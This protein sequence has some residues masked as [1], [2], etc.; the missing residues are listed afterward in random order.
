MGVGIEVS[1]L[2]FGYPN[3]DILLQD[4][5][6][7]ILAGE[8][9]CLLGPNGSGKTTLMRCLLSV[10]RI[11]TGNVSIGGCD[12]QSMS[13]KSL[14][15]EMAYVPQNTATVFPFSVFDMVLMGRTPHLSGFAVASDEDEQQV[16]HALARLEINHLKDR[17]FN[18]ISGGERQLVLI[19]RALCQK[20]RV[21][22]MDEPTASLDYGNQIRILQI[23][24]ELRQSGYAI[25]VSSHNPDHAL[26]SATHAAIMK[27]G[28]IVSLGSPDEVVTSRNLSDL[29]AADIR[30]IEASFPDQPGN[31]VKVCIPMM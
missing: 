30:V 11:R 17:A 15:R 8:T 21:M 13:R 29:Y 14:A 10:N 5:S 19:A 20:A 2:S 16:K 24:N 1:H 27:K 23:I 6:F 25:I 4:I 12:V 31:Q 28:H 3:Q 22:I 7:N 9:L 26:M 18:E